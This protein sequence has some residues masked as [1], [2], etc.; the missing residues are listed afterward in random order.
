M[1]FGIPAALH[2]DASVHTTDAHSG[3]PI[4][5]EVRDGQPVPQPCVIHFAVPAARWWEDIL[6]T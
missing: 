3:E 1:H 5:L 2:A 4:T 6:Y